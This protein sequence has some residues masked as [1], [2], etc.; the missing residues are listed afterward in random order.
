VSRQ[1]VAAFAPLLTHPA[2][3]PESGSAPP[4]VAGSMQFDG[5]VAGESHR[6]DNQAS[7]RSVNLLLLTRY[8]N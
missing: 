7:S 3:L 5:L 1:L 2:W 8:L 4:H 6:P